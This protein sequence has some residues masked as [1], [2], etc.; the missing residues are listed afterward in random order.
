MDIIDQLFTLF[1]HIKNLFLHFKRLK[2]LLLLNI[3]LLN[4]LNTTNESDNEAIVG[5]RASTPKKEQR[6]FIPMEEGFTAL[7]QL[8]G[9][10]Y[11]CHELE[12]NLFKKNIHRFME[13]SQ[14]RKKEH[15][16]QFVFTS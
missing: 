11:D 2:Y 8:F 14:C 7:Q 10:Y 15:L 12:Y 5:P 9:N 1:Q 6:I 3:L 16:L 13:Q 4:I